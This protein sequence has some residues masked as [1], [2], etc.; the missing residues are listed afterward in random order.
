MRVGFVALTDAAPL[1]VAAEFGFYRARGL[2]VTLVKQASWAA[3]RDAV[4]AGELDAAHCLS[5]LP[6]SVATGVSGRPDQRL[7]VV[8]VL[9]SDGQAITLGAALAGE[10]YGAV[11]D[12]LAAVAAASAR[13]RLTM[14]MTYPGGTHDIWL[15]Y[16]LAAAGVGAPALD[17][18]P[19]PPAQMVA[20][21]RAGTMDGFSAGEPWNAVAAGAGI[22]FTAIRSGQILPGHPEKALVVN[23]AV[24]AARRA[25]VRELTAATLEACRWLDVPA[26][27][28]RAAHIM[29]ARRHLNVPA[30]SIAPR[31]SGRYQRGGGLGAEDV[32]D[33]AVAFHRGGLVNAPRRGYA[34]WFMAQ[35]CRLGLLRAVPAFEAI[36]ADLVARDLYEEAA[37]SAGVDVPDDDMAPFGIP[38]DDAWFDPEDPLAE[39]LRRPERGSVAYGRA[40]RP[41]ALGGA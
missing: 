30:T 18:I 5:S 17:I 1:I 15:R 20:N 38:L 32:G 13:R 2:D 24:L 26:N 8:M 33:A 36:A 25:E 16:W 7:P 14:A 19:I 21:L 41:E 3:L 23:A 39:V 27:R 4:L 10:G 29:S 12:G 40:A 9:N 34:I 37:R 31:L 6:L 28:P 22:G 11:E 35:F